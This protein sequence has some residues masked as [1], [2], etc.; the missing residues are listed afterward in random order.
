MGVERRNIELQ[1]HRSPEEHR[2]QE[3]QGGH[4]HHHHHLSQ[5]QPPAYTPSSTGVSSLAE[6]G[7]D[8]AEGSGGG[9][10]PQLSPMSPVNSGSGGGF[11]K[12]GDL[13][14]FGAEG[15]FGDHAAVRYA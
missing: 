12:E 6:D 9:A 7:K 5:S 8:R 15:P 13:E 2:R 10:A 4:H 14:R 1:Y 3:Q 11:M